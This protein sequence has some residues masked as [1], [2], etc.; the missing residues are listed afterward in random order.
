MI[1]NVGHPEGQDELEEVLTATLGVAFANVA[2]DP[3]EDTNTLLIASEAPVAKTALRRAIAHLPAGLR[4]TARAETARLEAP[5]D[6][7]PVYTD[8]RAPVEWLIDR[9]IL[10]YAAGGE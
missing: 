3:I 9:S 6:D 1:V 2:R 7:G 8:D 5:L 4:A 10:D